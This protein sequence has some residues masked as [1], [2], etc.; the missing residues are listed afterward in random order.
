MT[1][2][3][4]LPARGTWHGRCFD[5]FFD[6]PARR[7]LG[8]SRAPPVEGPPLLNNIYTPL[9]GAI[10]QE[11]VLDQIANNLANMNTTG[12]KGDRIAFTL[13]APEPEKNYQDPLP[14]AN[15][16]VGVED[17]LHLKGNDMAYVGV[18]DVTRDDAQGP[19]IE[20]KNPLDVMIEGEGM[21]VVATP[22]GER[23]TR[24]GALSVSRDGVLETKDGYPVLGDKG[25]ILVHAGDVQINDSGEV[26]QDGHLVDR[27]RLVHFAD[28]SKL[29][30]IGGNLFFHGGP[31]EAVAPV[32][33]PAMRQ[34][35]LEGSNVNAIK[36]LTDMIIAHRSYEAYQKAVQNYDSMMQKTSNSVGELRG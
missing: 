26:W 17:L 31:P 33:F 27:L 16:K 25:D 20:T 12:F 5:L 4:A 24:N 18:A 36:N 35:Y 28:A 22:D 29:E 23:Y 15:Y 11:R 14:P 7:F 3:R 19:A 2:R 9:S 6:T 21:L 30:R 1:R 13:L 8:A 34:G 32:A 10:A